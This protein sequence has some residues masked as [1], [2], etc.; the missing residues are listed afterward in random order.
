MAIEPAMSQ[1]VHK[2]EPN[3]PHGSPEM[4]YNVLNGSCFMLLDRSLQKQPL[5]AVAP[6]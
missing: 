4:D 1:S 6:P 2:P 5:E 3:M